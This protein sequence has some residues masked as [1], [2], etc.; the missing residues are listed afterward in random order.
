MNWYHLAILYMFSF[1]LLV[2][3]EN[4]LFEKPVG[5]AFS[6]KIEYDKKMDDGSNSKD[7]FRQKIKVMKIKAVKRLDENTYSEANNYWYFKDTG[8]VYD[9]ENDFPVGKIEINNEGN[10]VKIDNETYIIDTLI[11]IPEFKIYE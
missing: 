6:Q 1:H 3:F 10:P 11:D 9:I 8:I 5:P 4:S 2:L 7:S